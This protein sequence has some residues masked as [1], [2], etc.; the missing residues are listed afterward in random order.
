MRPTRLAAIV[1]LLACSVVGCQIG[2]APLSSGGKLQLLSY[3][4]QD[5]EGLDCDYRQSDCGVPRNRPLTFRFDRWLLPSTATRQSISLYVDQ[6]TFVQFTQPTYDLIT[7]TVT[8]RPSGGLAQGLVHLL[9]LGDSA[10][11][12]NGWGFT[13]Y[14]RQPLSRDNLPDI[15]VFRTGKADAAVEPVPR[16]RTSCRDALLAFSRAGCA[17]SHCHGTVD[18]NTPLAG[19]S[20]DTARGLRATIG[21][22]ALATDRGGDSGRATVMPERFG[23]NLPLIEPSQPAMS[24]LLYRILLGRDA[25]RNARGRFEVSPP[26]VEELE[27][28]TTWF[29][30]MGPMP[31]D[32]VGY[33]EGVSPIELARTVQ[34]WILD[35]A[36][37]SHCE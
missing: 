29:G 21:K 24:F 18:G 25:Y 22:V 26:S 31:P 3:E 27:R 11:D 17:S 35:G 23:F 16:E 33:P 7:R 19:L 12:P 37:T 13:A 1:S 8:Y 20:L 32:A 15:I 28:A 10:T 5:A 36:D 6:S 9:E 14:D 4:P 34:G 2:E 30:A